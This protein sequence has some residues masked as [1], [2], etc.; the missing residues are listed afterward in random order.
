[1]TNPVLVEFLRG[2]QPESRHRGSVV[3][4]RGAE[5]VHCAGAF[6]QP[7][8]V[9]S[10]A[11]P[12][13]LAAAYVAGAFDGLALR[14]EEL[15]VMCASHNGEARHVEVVAGL[16][17]RAGFTESDLGCGSHPSISPAVTE[18]QTR[19]G[20]RRTTIHNNC[21]GKHTAMLLFARHL[22]ADPASY[23]DPGHP[24]QR[25]IAD[26]VRECCGLVLPYPT[27]AV[28]GCSAPTFR[29]PLIG[30]AHGFRRLIDPD[31]DEPSGSKL[32]QPLRDALRAIR[33]AVLAEPFMIAG[34]SR[35]DTE[36]IAAGEGSLISKVGAEGIIACGVAPTA[37]RPALGIAIKIDD[38]AP[39]AYEGLL[40][41]LLDR[42]GVLDAVIRTRLARWLDPAIRNHKG[43]V[44]GSRRTWSPPGS[45]A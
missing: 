22:G 21:S 6:E 24:A 13:Q 38:G 18:Q 36:L 37:T 10:A 44:T 9:R 28:D 4:T 15:A 45:T 3:V 32:R 12:F 33:D 29:M 14:N 35:I 23:L 8:F 39:R 16:L 19:E 40:L 26:A 20:V 1:M 11:K 7:E 17:A 34:S 25:A 42:L 2:D 31:A 41:D 43:V 5:V 27:I 30:L